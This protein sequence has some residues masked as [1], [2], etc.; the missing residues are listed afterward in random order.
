MSSDK[1][2]HEETSHR[3]EVCHRTECR[4]FAELVARA[5]EGYL[6]TAE[7]VAPSRD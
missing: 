1:K 6:I 4:Q 2:P 7:E 3:R 5:L